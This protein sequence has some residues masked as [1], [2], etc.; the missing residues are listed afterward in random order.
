MARQD[1]YKRQTLDIFRGNASSLSN[2][3]AEKISLTGLPFLFK[4]MD[5]FEAMAQSSLGQELLDS[6]DEMCIRDSNYSS[7]HI[8]QGDDDYLTYNS[9]YKTLGE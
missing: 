8:E 3:G 6:V 4:D 9:K 7:G 2:Y 5:Q 1:V